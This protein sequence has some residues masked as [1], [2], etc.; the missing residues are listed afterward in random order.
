[1]WEVSW[2]LNRTATYWLPLLWP[3]QRFFP[4]L[5]RCSTGAWGPSLSGTW[6]SFQHLLS[7]SSEALNF[8]CSIRGPEGPLCWVL[9]LSTASSPTDLNFLSPGLYNNLT[10]TYFLRSS[11][12]RTQFNPLTV[13][14]ISWYSL[15]GC[16]CY[17]QRRIS[18]FDSSAGVNMQQ[19]YRGWYAI[20]ERNWNFHHLFKSSPDTT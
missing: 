20:K 3:W 6:S 7:N 19:T 1:M 14:V 17:L 4:V 2:S 8:N 12:F 11:Q 13:N 18:Y 10:S 16:T 15:T 5:L 9:V